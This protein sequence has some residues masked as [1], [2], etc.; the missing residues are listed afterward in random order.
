MY[1]FTRKLL[2]LLSPEQA[3]RFAMGVLAWCCRL[4]V[5]R[6]LIRKAYRYPDPDLSQTIWGLHFP[7]PV[8]LAAGFDKDARYTDVLDCLG[9]GFVEIGTVTPMPQPGN[10]APRLFRLQEDQALI[11]RM[12]FNNQGSGAAAQRLKERKPGLLIG[13]NIGKNKTTPNDQAVSD[14]LRCM[15]DLYG[16]VDY[17][18][19]NLSSPNT[20]GLR[21]L[22]EKEPLKQILRALRDRNLQ[23]GNPRPL[24]LKIAPDLSDSQLEDLLVVVKETGIDGIVATNTTI[25]RQGLRTPSE[26]LERIG[27]GGLSGRPLKPRALEIVGRIR[28]AT[29]GKLPI[30]AVGGI[31][32]ADDARE[33]M[34]AGAWL[35]QVYT[36]FI[37]QG[38]GIAREICRGLDPSLLK[39]R[40]GIPD[41]A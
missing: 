9:F 32:T 7:N 33:M 29:E 21:E 14:Y 31:F 25:D 22:Q 16:Q 26:E 30:I 6:S 5:F 27:P 23:G 13:G 17:F 24:L 20:P 36:G 10:P 28:R 11:N 34:E 40:K 8:G 18:V 37:Y 12:G 3:H 4:S 19:V 38:P 41:M 39:A 35:V 1:A 2:F 15:D